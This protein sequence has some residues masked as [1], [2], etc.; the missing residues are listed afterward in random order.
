MEF[1]ILEFI[2]NQLFE[3]SVWCTGL[4]ISMRAGDDEDD[5]SGGKGLRGR[6]EL[7]T[8]HFASAQPASFGGYSCDARQ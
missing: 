3:L 6:T 5:I 7:E 4:R 2:N 8:I 1:E